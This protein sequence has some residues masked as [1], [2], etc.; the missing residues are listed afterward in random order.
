MYSLVV[1]DNIHMPKEQQIEFLNNINRVGFEDAVALINS[2]ALD[3]ESLDVLI[4]YASAREEVI[5]LITQEVIDSLESE[6]I[7]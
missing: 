6:S 2:E 7:M 5:D 1:W 3:N 4:R